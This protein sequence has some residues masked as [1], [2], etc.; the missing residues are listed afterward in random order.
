MRVPTEKDSKIRR[1]LGTSQH[2]GGRDSFL[3]RGHF[4]LK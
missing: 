2:C 1:V 3:V 4:A